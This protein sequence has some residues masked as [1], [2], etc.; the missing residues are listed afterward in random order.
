[1][2]SIAGS[3][4]DS[5]S[6]NGATTMANLISLLRNSDQ[7]FI[8]FGRISILLNNSSKDSRRPAVSAQNK[9]RDFVV[10]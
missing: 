3:N 2:T 6:A 10:C 8:G 7:E 4:K 9:I 1:M 5:P